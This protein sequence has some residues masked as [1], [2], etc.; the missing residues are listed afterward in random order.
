[1]PPQNQQ[2]Q[3]LQDQVTRMKGELES[4][5]QSFYKNN[6]SGSQTFNKDVIFSTRLKVPVYT[7]APAVGEV[8]DIISYTDG[9]G[10]GQLYICT[11]AGNVATPATF[12]KVGTQS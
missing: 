2:L 11:V 3:D 8:G 4:L 7:T 6:F 10:A 12:S 1:M 5:S 9:S